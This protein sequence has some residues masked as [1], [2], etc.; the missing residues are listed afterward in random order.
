MDKFFR[1]V[2]Q[3]NLK[4]SPRFGEISTVT[5]NLRELLKER[6]FL[7]FT[8]RG[9]IEIV[10]NLKHYLTGFFL[11]VVCLFKILQFVFFGVS[12]FF[13][14]VIYQNNAINSQKF[15]ES[16][17][18]TLKNIANDVQNL[19]DSIIEIEED[20][21]MVEDFDSEIVNEDSLETEIENLKKDQG[22]KLQIKE[23][24]NNLRLLVSKLN[25]KSSNEINKSDEI[26]FDQFAKIASPE[27]IAIEHTIE[28]KIDVTEKSTRRNR[29]SFSYN[30]LPVIPFTAPRSNKTKIIHFAKKLDLEILQLV[31]VFKTLKLS[32]DNINLKEIDAFLTKSSNIQK[33]ADLIENA[34]IRFQYLE[35]LKNAI[36]YLPL[37]PPMQYYYISSPYGVRVHPK[38][39]KKRMHHGIDMA[40]TWQE[41]VR[42]AA[43]GYVSSAGR[44][45]SFGKT[46]KI[47]HKHGVTTLYGHLH[48]LSVKKGD[49]VEEG[50]I[51][52]KMG[53]TGRVVGAH[54][55]YE[56]RVN[57]KRANPY[58]FISLG[59]ELLSRSIIRR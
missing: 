7:F 6:R 33:D 41:E 30:N 22:F 1:R 59:R 53:A 27:M 35:E 28:K 42:A 2:L 29:E 47:I 14:Y 8:K 21:E 52:G 9:P 15:T 20:L 37:K 36:I 11:G 32:P 48:R 18:E 46:I 26:I 12:I 55:H 58:N 3:N 31:N 43:D 49:Y 16:E 39:K 44:N 34:S 19:D 13:N 23:K 57:K 25:F 40:G 51:I 38:T 56:I 54:L 45:G 50:Q 10:F 4:S 5:K 17:I 24:F